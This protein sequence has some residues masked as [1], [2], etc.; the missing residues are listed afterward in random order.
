MR[1]KVY[2]APWYNVQ[3]AVLSSYVPKEDRMTKK[4]KGE[5]KQVDDLLKE[6]AKYEVKELDRLKAIEAL[7]QEGDSQ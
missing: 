1:R 6:Y 5:W 4:K 3:Q 7:M 2:G